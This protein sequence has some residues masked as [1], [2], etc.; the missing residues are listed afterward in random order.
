MRN[1]DDRPPPTDETLQ[2][3]ASAA[4]VGPTLPDPFPGEFRL[5][6][7]LGEGAFGQVYLAEDLKLRRKVALKTLRYAGDRARLAALQHEA[8]ILA[9]FRAWGRLS[10]P[11]RDGAGWLSAAHHFARSVPKLNDQNAF[12]T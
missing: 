6:G 1:G 7:L 9:Q 2:H 10:T 8:G 5:V 3:G 4:P 12:R 11:R